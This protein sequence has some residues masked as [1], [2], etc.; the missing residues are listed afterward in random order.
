MK[1]I[2]EKIKALL[3]DRAQM[4]ELVLYLVFGVATTAVNWLAYLG[5]TQALGIGSQAEGSGPYL[6]ISNVGQVLGWEL[7]VLFAYATTK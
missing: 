7:S 5:V 3:K 1:Q 2:I 6:L 4:R